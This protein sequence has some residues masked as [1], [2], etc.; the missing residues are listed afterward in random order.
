VTG[1]SVA[2]LMCALLVSLLAGLLVGYKLGRVDV[3]MA[4]SGIV[5]CVLAAYKPLRGLRK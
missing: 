5:G 4:V 1:T 2:L 3:A